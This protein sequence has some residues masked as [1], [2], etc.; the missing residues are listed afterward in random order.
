MTIA[1]AAA[2]SPVRAASTRPPIDGPPWRTSN[3]SHADSASAAP[4]ASLLSRSTTFVVLD[5][6]TSVVVWRDWRIHLLLTCAV[7]GDLLRSDQCAPL[8]IRD[9]QLWTCG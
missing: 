3:P 9:V 5:V 4:I 6:T 8:G 1:A 7:E 2:G